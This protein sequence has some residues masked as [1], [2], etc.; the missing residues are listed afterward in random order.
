MVPRRRLELP[1]PFGH[2]HLK[3]EQSTN[4]LNHQD[5][6]TPA[7][8]G[9]QQERSG[10]S[11]LAVS[12]MGANGAQSGVPRCTGQPKPR[13]PHAAPSGLRLLPTTTLLPVHADWAAVA[14]LGRVRPEMPKFSTTSL[15]RECAY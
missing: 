1:R 13:I 14:S 6:V 15:D 8:A 9:V 4:G 2:E 12:R 10:A 5:F 3:L 7:Q 11:P